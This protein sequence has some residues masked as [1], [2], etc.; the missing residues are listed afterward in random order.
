MMY[1]VVIKGSLSFVTSDKIMYAGGI[2]S[3]QLETFVWFPLSPSTGLSLKSEGHAGQ[4]MGPIVEV[5]PSLGR[6]RFAKSPEALI[7]RCQKPSPQ[8]GNSGFVD[9]LN[10]L[11]IHGS[12]QLYAV[13]R[14]AVDSAFRS[15]QHPSGYRYQ[16]I[17][18]KKFY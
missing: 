2:E 13:D 1:P 3:E 14:S 16:P 5:N 18:D 6:I 8:E 9:A 10:G 4:I 15:A 11:M 12:T 17:S 7:L